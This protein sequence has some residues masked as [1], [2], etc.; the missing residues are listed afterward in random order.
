MIVTPDS[1]PQ[2]WRLR[3]SDPKSRSF[4]YQFVYHFKDGTQRESQPVTT[5]AAAVAVNDPFERP[6]EIIFIPAFTPGQQRAVF[7]DVE[8]HDDASNYHREERLRIAGDSTEETR[9]RLALIN[10]LKRTFKYRFTFV[11]LDGK[12]NSKTPVETSETLISIIE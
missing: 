11:D 7:V 2:Y 1:E 5:L 4:A 6:L 12:I 9:L 8:Y 3:L 10:P